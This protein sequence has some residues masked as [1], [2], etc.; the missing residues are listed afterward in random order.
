[1]RK[2]I[3]FII[4][5]LSINAFNR[6]VFAQ[7]PAKKS[8]YEFK[9]IKSLPA[10][11]VKDQHRTGTCWS[12]ATIS[13]LESEL[14]RKG[15]GEFDLSEMYPVRICYEYKAEKYVRMH[16]KTNFAHGGL[17]QDLLWVLD[18][19]GLVPE[20][21]YG[22]L[23]YGEDK[24]VH[25]EMDAVVSGYMEHLISNRNGRLTP[26]WKEG[27][28]GILDA[29]FGKVP[30]RFSYNGKDYTP[31]EFAEMLNLS[32]SDYIAVGSFTHHPFYETFILE[33]P[34]NWMWHNIYNVPINDMMQVL[35]NALEQGYTVL[36]DADVSERGFDRK[37]SIALVPQE[38]QEEIMNMDRNRWSSLSDQEK[39]KLLYDFSTPKKERVITQEMRQE[40]FNNYMTSDDHLMH[41]TG[42][43]EDQKGNPFYLVK[44]SWGTEELV[45]DGYFYVSRTYMQ[46]KTLFFMV[47]KEAIPE[48][49]RDRLGI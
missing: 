45:Y 30:E 46:Y 20:A 49:L 10:T 11:P 5:L 16:G 37:T 42:L 40:S 19:Y 2:S 13:F 3:L 17:G 41:I 29:Y 9:I 4:A 18:H 6:P 21:V 34:D 12:F 25:G 44:N 1:M 38:E 14:L 36:W 23:E 33:V 24:H 8:G 28:K 47:H 15:K 39:Q 32:S 27:L 43:A 35:D 22:G 48:A 31:A 26:V 7:G